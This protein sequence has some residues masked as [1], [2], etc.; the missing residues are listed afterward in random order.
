MEEKILSQIYYSR[1]FRTRNADE[2][3]LENILDLFIDPTDGLIGPFDF[4]N[5][6]VKGKMGSGKTM[7]LRANYAYYLHTLVP[8]LLEHDSIILPV[9]IKL[10]DFQHLKDPKEIYDSILVKIIEEIL[11]VCDHL[12]S[13]EEM[14]RLHKGAITLTGNWSTDNALIKIGNRLKELSAD[15]YVEKIANSCETKGGIVNHFFEVCANYNKS[16][17]IEIK[18]HRTPEFSDVVYAMRELITPFNGKL[19]ILFDEI[20]S[21]NKLFFKN[22]ENGDSY[23]EILMNQLRTISNIRTK[24]AVYPNTS[25]D[26]L[27]ETRYGD[28][29]ALECDA[30]NHP[31]LYSSYSIKIISLIEKYISKAIEEACSAEEIFDIST[32]NQLLIEQLINASSGNMRRLVHLL[33]SSMNQAYKRNNGNGK[34]ILDDIIDALKKQGA[35]MEN[36]YQS[37]DVDFLINISKFCKTRS[38]YRFSYPN[39]GTTISKFT[40]NSEEYNIIE[41]GQYG[42]G[43][44]GTIYYF[45]YAYCIYKDLPTHY[46]KN[47]EKIDKTRSHIKGEPIRRVAQLTDGLMAQSMVPGKIDGEIT[48]LVADK[49]AGFIKGNDDREYFFSNKNIIK[50]D[51]KR[52]Y[53]VKH[54][55]RF[56]PSFFTDNEKKEISIATEIE[57]L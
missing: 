19:L 47:S 44:K 51:V 21:I 33:D 9:Y 1:P 48:F 8:C 45:D 23:F 7:Y 42:T 38:T 56:L 16:K 32:Q 13:A 6:I 5:V 18:S 41:I 20:G 57:V 27:K 15:E 36:L 22:D 54:K 28:V 2:F 49:S 29:V 31:E 3:D 46:I 50:D 26:I 53:Y 30:I 34:I 40:N 14:T 4:A 37:D 25:S 24:L 12:K 43:R 35:D 39:K 17:S 52:A 10:S 55:V 11:A